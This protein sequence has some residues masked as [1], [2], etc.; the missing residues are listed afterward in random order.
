MP[1]GGPGAR[2]VA[3]SVDRFAGGRN[4]R[5]LHGLRDT[6]GSETG[7]GPDRDAGRHLLRAAAAPGPGRAPGARA[8][9][10]LIELLVVVAIVG[11]LA[12]MLVPSFA[13]ARSITLRT[14]CAAN[15]R[16]IHTAVT[17]YVHT[18][19]DTYPCAQDPVS[20]KPYY[21]LWMGRGWRGLVAP[22]LGGSVSKD[23]PSVLLCPGDP[24]READTYTNPRPSIAQSPFQVADPAR[25][26]LIGEWTSNHP[27]AS[28]DS[29]WW[30]WQGSRNFLFADGAVRYLR[31]RQIR[32]GRDGLP[33]ANL[34]VHG[35]EGR[36]L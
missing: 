24:K 10:T 19:K 20:T 12:G 6:A 17:L 14:R 23:K 3:A 32:P 35:I 34:T 28:D 29:G 21:W 8:G 30:C 26:V 33:D 22:Y 13:A 25:K 2:L 36:D 31:A 7:R 11:L 9:F 27:R 15:L 4:G 18:H 5:R 1:S 16:H